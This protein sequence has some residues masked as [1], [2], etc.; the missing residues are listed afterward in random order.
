MGEELALD[1][2]LATGWTS[3]SEWV[4]EWQSASPFL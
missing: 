2:L 4:A 1:E 3:A